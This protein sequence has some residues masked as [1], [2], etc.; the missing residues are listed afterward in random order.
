MIVIDNILLSDPDDYLDITWSLSS[1]DDNF[2]FEL[3]DFTPFVSDNNKFLKISLKDPYDYESL[4]WADNSRTDA[5]WSL[6]SLYRCEVYN[7][8]TG[9]P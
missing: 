6:H 9:W 3:A 2:L 7:S 4:D 5:C 8:T 1:N